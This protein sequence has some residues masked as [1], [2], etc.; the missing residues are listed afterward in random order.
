MGKY[1]YAISV[2]ELGSL[3]IHTLYLAVPVQSC[4]G[5]VSILTPTLWIRCHH[6]DDIIRIRVRMRTV[7]HSVTSKEYDY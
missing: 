5:S 3:C 1:W 4:S 6:D 7:I 2:I